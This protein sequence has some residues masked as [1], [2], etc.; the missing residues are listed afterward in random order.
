MD[1]R[2]SAVGDMAILFTGFTYKETVSSL[3]SLITQQSQLFIRLRGNTLGHLRS[4][5]FFKFSSTG[6]FP[7]IL[8]STLFS[9]ICGFSQE[10]SRH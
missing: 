9:S 3:S 10:P 7:S 1:L 8:P 4:P 5:A 2:S 6:C